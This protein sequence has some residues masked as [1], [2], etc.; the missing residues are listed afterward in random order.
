MSDSKIFMK[1]SAAWQAEFTKRLAA[2]QTL[3]DTHRAAEEEFEAK[4]LA[5]LEALRTSW[6]SELTSPQE[7]LYEVA[8]ISKSDI[9]AL[10]TRRAAYSDRTAALMAKIA[11]LS[12]VTFEDT[13]KKKIL[14]GLFKHGDVHLLE[15]LSLQETEV[16]VV[17][18]KKCV[19]AAFR[20]TTS[21]HDFRTDLQARFNVAKVE[22]ENKK[23]KVAVHS[24]FFS[25]YEKVAAPLEAL[26]M[27]TG[28]KPIYLT[29][30]SLG[31]ALA[32]IASAVLGGKD[33]LG[34]RIAAV[35]TFGA[36]RVGKSDFADI[37]KAPHYRCVN[38]GDLVPLVPPTWI[39]GYAHTGTPF[40]LK[41]NAT[42]PLRR[43]PYRVAFLQSLLS[44]PLW[45][46]TR[47][48]PF[49]RAH[50]TSLY[51]AN[52]DKIARHRGKWT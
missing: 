2:Y 45:P 51:V 40:L 12:Y 20:G 35:Y 33:Q 32:L 37:V 47:N 7:Q 11:M 6:V 31:G 29:G 44:L 3:L 38:S 19:I 36:P 22:I 15:T 46:F 18:T 5:E 4:R 13:E 50:D 43:S 34:D 16:L 48:M 28:D 17:D 42:K 21:K 39:L 10:P 30:H 41:K 27:K 8:P 1:D 9:E 52:L 26:L 24:G 14:E 49:L 25:A 23:I